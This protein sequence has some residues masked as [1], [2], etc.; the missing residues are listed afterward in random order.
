MAGYRRCEYTG[1]VRPGD[2]VAVFGCGGVGCAAIAGAN[3]AGATRS[4]RSTSM[5]ESWDV[6]REFGATHSHGFEFEGPNRA[7]SPSASR[8]ATAPTCA[9]RRSATRP[10]WNRA[11][12]ARDL[13]GTRVQV[14]VPRPDYRIDLPM[15]EFFWPRWTH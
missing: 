4:S 15:I 2:S 13:A 3:L 11:F 12:Y 14:G 7:D 10:S 9:L 1:G 8:E 6:A 5:L